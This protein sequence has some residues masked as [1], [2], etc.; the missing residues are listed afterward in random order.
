[1]AD[2]PAPT[3]FHVQ[4]LF[5]PML[6][7]VFLNMILYGVLL[8]QMYFYFQT[9]KTEVI[10]IRLLV[11]YLFIVET[12]NTVFD[13]VMMYQPLIAE[14][15]TTKAVDNFPTRMLT[16]VFESL[17][18]LT[19][20]FYSFCYRT[21][22]GR[23]CLILCELIETDQMTYVFD[24]GCCFGSHPM[25]LCLE[26]LEDYEINVDTCYHHSSL[27][28][29]IGQVSGG[30]ITAIKIA[31]I[32]LFAR[33]PELHWPALLWFLTS[34]VADLLITVTLVRTLSQRKTGFGAT[35]TMIDK[36]IR[37]TVQTGM[38]TAICAIGDVAFFMALP[39][40]ALNFVW[41][42]MLSKLYANCLL[43]TLN[44]RSNIRHGSQRG[45][46]VVFKNGL[47]GM[48]SREARRQTDVRLNHS[49]I[50]APEAYELNS[51]KTFDAT[52]SGMPLEYH[53]DGE[54]DGYGIT[55]TKVVETMDDHHDNTGMV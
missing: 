10:W 33:K 48:N 46:S 49:T 3:V 1:M 2:P 21:Y 38:I 37:L 12:A 36:L 13:M 32:K 9:Y 6:L 40:A 52:H 18:W 44:A 35:D 7:G 41:D 26:N 47:D 17:H 22:Y 43:S 4:L 30:L 5:G 20:S 8:N 50:A 39:H 31:I 53:G 45:S 34:C 55:V 28:G 14:Y 19:T 23:K 27:F 54:G 42:L 29:I 51:T 24:S 11:I 15:G 25:L 16:A